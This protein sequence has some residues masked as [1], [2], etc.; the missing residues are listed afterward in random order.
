MSGSISCGCGLVG[1]T[2]DQSYDHNEPDEGAGGSTPP[3]DQGLAPG[4]PGS[5]T[6]SNVPLQAP[7]SPTSST[8]WASDMSDVEL[9]FRRS[10]YECGC[11]L[12]LRL[13]CSPRSKGQDSLSV[14]VVVPA[15]SNAQNAGTVFQSVL[16]KA[17]LTQWCSALIAP[18]KVRTREVCPQI[19][20]NP[21][22][23]LTRLARDGCSIYQVLVNPLRNLR[24]VCWPGAE[25]TWRS[26]CRL[27]AAHALQ[28]QP[29]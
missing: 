19:M 7:P 15:T 12:R 2:H 1:I 22:M 26:G 5:R 13:H 28:P 16:Y 27:W 4:T 11:H 24:P 20:P 6:V 3:D 8:A 14:Q 9:V 25:V 29:G 23:G 21:G 17:Q 10:G 18:T